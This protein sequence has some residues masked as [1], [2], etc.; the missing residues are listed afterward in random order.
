MTPACPSWPLA[1]ITCSVILLYSL[2]LSPFQMVLDSPC[3]Q[4]REMN[5]FYVS[6]SAVNICVRKALVAFLREVTVSFH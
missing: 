1:L 2:L 4:G 6:V 5:K 3:Y